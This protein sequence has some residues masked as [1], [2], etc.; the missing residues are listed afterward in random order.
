MIIPTLFQSLCVVFLMQIEGTPFSLCLVVS[1]GAK[2]VSYKY[3]FHLR[4]Y[5]FLFH[6]QVE[7][8]GIKMC[9]LFKRA[10]T[11][12]ALHHVRIHPV[13]MLLRFHFQLGLTRCCH[14]RVIYFPLEETIYLTILF[15]KLNF[16]VGSGLEESHDVIVLFSTVK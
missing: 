14:S 13:A 10:V 15:D 9:N 5:T 12:G 8:S 1:Q 7:P 4:D 6:S 16:I 2:N 11:K 3:R